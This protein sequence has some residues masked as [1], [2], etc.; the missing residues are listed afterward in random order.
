MN[1]D[2]A[3]EHSK[4]EAILRILEDRYPHS[5]SGTELASLVDLPVENV[6]SFLGFLAKYSFSTYDEQEKKAIIHADFSSLE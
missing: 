3:G 2:S 1:E 4:I 6:D 5:V